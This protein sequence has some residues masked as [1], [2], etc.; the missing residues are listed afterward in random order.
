M[1]F[2]FEKLLYKLSD[3]VVLEKSNGFKILD[4]KYIKET[5]KK[6]FK[7][8]LAEIGHKTIGKESFEI[9][10]EYKNKIFKVVAI[11][12][13][14]NSRIY[15]FQEISKLKEFE[16]YKNM[17][18]FINQIQ[19]NFVEKIFTGNFSK[20]DWKVFL[21]KFVK[22]FPNIDF[23]SLILKDKNGDFKYVSVYNHDFEGLKNL[24]LKKEDFVPERFEKVTVIKL[25]EVLEEYHFSG[26]RRKQILEKLHKYGN[27]T[28][29]KSLVSIPIFIENECIGFVVAD[30]WEREDAFDNKVFKDFSK[31]LSEILS[32]VFQHSNLYEK[33]IL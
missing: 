7:L 33:S 4:T 22:I 21:R 26:K 8:F 16:M 30:N 23:A 29:I 25:D 12:T 28:R 3:I 6:I 5:S 2:I 13:E 32:K 19:K 10:Y 17:L 27:L 24:R 15:S 1:I 31:M 14:E 20:K 18:E 11:E 9:E